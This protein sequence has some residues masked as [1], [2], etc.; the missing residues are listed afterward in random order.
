ML[1][2]LFA[3]STSG[4]AQ[5]KVVVTNIGEQ[6]NVTSPVKLQLIKKFQ[7]MK[8]STESIDNVFD[9]HVLSPKS[10]HFLS[11]KGKVYVNALEGFQ[12]IVYSIE[13]WEKLK[14]ITHTFKSTEDSLFNANTVFGY[15]YANRTKDFN[16]FSGK[17]VEFT[18][19]HNEKYLWV[20]YY[21]RSYDGNAVSPSAVAIIDTDTDKIVR[22]MPT[23]PLPKMIA[24]SPDNKYVAVTHWGDNTVGIIDIS[25]NDVK[26]FRYVKH[27]VVGERLSFNFGEE[28]VNR[29]ANC[30]YCLRGTTFSSDGKYLLVGRMGGIGAIAFFNMSDLS[31]QGTIIGSKNNVRH[32]TINK[33]DLFISTN[34]SG[35]VQKA[36]MQTLISKVE[37]NKGKT[38]SFHGWE[39]CYVGV[40]ARTISVSHDG[41]YIFAAVNYESKIV[42]V[43]REQMKKVCHIFADSFPVGMDISKEDDYLAVT[44]QGK[45]KVGGGHSFMIYS[46]DYLH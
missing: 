36:P 45:S 41:R 46:I 32:I 33:G 26:E 43:D 23:G 1:L 29:D 40:G 13:T 25:G 44:A 4:I 20:T 21:R 6:S 28:K 9:K 18:T 8:R 3:I 38:A 42:V 19:S 2:L 14:V 7:L 37:E 30:G 39:G 22:V 15:K 12:T 10:A 5:P 34:K 24:T 31:Y 35:Y 27:F 17:P 11:S 16:I